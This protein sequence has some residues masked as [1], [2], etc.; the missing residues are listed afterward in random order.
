VIPFAKSEQDGLEIG[1]KLQVDAIVDSRIQQEGDRLRVTM[2][3]VRVANGE[4]VWSG[5]FDGR[6][7]RILDLQDMIS[8]KVSSS[9]DASV[10]DP[11]AFAKRPT[12]SPEA[13]EAYLKGRYFWTRRDEPSLRKAVEYFTQA[14]T[15][16]PNFSEAFSGLADTQHLLFNYNIDVRPA[17]VTE[18]R[19]NLSRALELK[20][21]SPDALITLG[22]IEMGY[23]WDWKTAEQ[24]LR[25]AVAAAPNSPTAH[26]RYGALLVRI[27]RF[28]EAQAEFEKQTELDPLSITG[29]INLGMVRFCKKDYAGADSQYSKALELDDKAGAPHWLLSRSMW[30]QGK[31]DESVRE[32]IRALELDGNPS[33][34]GRIGEKAQTSPAEEAIQLL[35][36]EWRMNPPGTNPHNLAYLSTYVND[37]EKA[38]YWLEK[39]IEE[40]H[41]WTTWISAAP[42]FEVLRGEPRYLGMLQKMNLP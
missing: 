1:R 20:P 14:S 41:P 28:D 24:T 9:L 22:T 29:I 19:Q 32:I 26:M 33:L 8:A 35:L 21:G 16:D 3:L 12:D 5:Q 34:A 7:D 11:E 25:Q 13:Y 42:E 30:M 17:L 38:I 10:S 40:H 36:Y 23:D 2:Q 27:R 4:Q 15:L 18:A 31:K 6:A 37:T 39:S